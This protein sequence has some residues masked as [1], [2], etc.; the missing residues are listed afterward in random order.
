[1]PRPMV[2]V[3]CPE[4]PFTA[5]T[6]VPWSKL[7]FHMNKHHPKDKSM[8]CEKCDMY[9]GSNAMIRNHMETHDE[10]KYECQFCG[11]KYRDKLNFDSHVRDHTGETPYSCNI[12]E[13]AGSH[14]VCKSSVLLRRH[15]QLT[16]G[17][18]P[19]PKMAH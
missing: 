12:C 5:E 11:S 9:F 6:T 10:P 14:F 17:L 7:S 16:H 2:T 3:K 18:K 15:K 1:M 13:V 19:K 4:C 8:Y